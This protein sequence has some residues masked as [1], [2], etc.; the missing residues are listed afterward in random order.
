[1]SFIANRVFLSAI[2][3]CGTIL[4]SSAE[5]QTNDVAVCESVS[6][7]TSIDA[8]TRL[9]AS[10]QFNGAP[11]ATIFNNRGEAYDLMGEDEKAFADFS[12]A[13][14]LNPNFAAAFDN[15][16]ELYRWKGDYER[17]IADYNSAIRLDPAN[18][19]FWNGRC[20]MRA[21]MKRDLPEALTDCDEALK[22]LPNSANALDSRALTYLQAGRLDEAL[23]DY[24]AAL[25]QQPNKPHSLYGRGLVKLK[26][27]DNAGGEADLAAAK[28]AD[29][30]IELEFAH[31]KLN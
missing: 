7:Q 17:G 4:L 6:G 5:A 11:L 9:I 1:M 31:F 30:E 28:A 8:C 10:K 3:L 16:A 25:A 13:L 2:A 29:A 15:R 21:T 23:A 24:N 20:W 14:R 26:K 18:P 12:E 27:G 22:R 19:A